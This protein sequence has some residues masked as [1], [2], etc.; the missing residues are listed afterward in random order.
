MR[1]V[2]LNLLVGCSLIAGMLVSAIPVGA[3]S[4]PSGSVRSSANSY[5]ECSI[6][7][8]DADQDLM[9]RVKVIINVVIG[10]LGIVA[11][12]MIIIGGIMYTTSQGQ[13]DKVKQAKDIIMYSVIGLIVA[14]LAFAIVNFVLSGVFGRSI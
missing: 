6:P 4:C 11:V 2:L 9:S 14:L 13:P 1:K 8:D 12:A 5:A 3:V 10:V 7:E